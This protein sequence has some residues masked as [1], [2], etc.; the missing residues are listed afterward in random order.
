MSKSINWQE[1][2][3]IEF[4]NTTDALLEKRYGITSNDTSIELIAAAQEAGETPEEI[5][6]FIGEKYDL[7]E[8]EAARWVPDSSG[9]RVPAL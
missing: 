4:L 7:H 6:A 5:V 3:F 1:R 8:S 2:P 9:R